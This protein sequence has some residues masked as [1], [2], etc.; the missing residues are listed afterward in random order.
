[1]PHLDTVEECWCACIRMVAQLDGLHHAHQPEQ[2]GNLCKV[3]EIGGVVHR[4]YGV[5]GHRCE[6]IHCQPCAGIMTSNG[7]TA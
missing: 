5:P 7:A 1:M 3:E 2:P 4:E 6:D